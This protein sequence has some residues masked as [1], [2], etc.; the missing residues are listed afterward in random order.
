MREVPNNSEKL[1]FW[2]LPFNAQEDTGVPF[3][4]NFSYILRKGHRKNFLWVGSRK[5]PIFGYVPKNDEKNNLVHKGL[6]K[7]KI[8]KLH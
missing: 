8:S 3:H 6:K 2:R 7:V 5:E 1:F 4:W